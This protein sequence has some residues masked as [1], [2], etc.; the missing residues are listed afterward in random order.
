MKKVEPFFDPSCCSYRLSTKIR[1]HVERLIKCKDV[2]QETKSVLIELMDEDETNK[3][4]L[5][6]ESLTKLHKYIQRADPDYVGP[7]YIFSESCKCIRPK[8]RE[9]KQ[10]EARLKLLRL[11]SSQQMYNNMT[12]TVDRVVEKKIDEQ[13]DI[14]GSE[15][16][17]LK[18]LSG[19]MMAVINSFLV[20]ICTFIFC[21]KAVE[22]SLPQPNIIAQVSFGLLGS[23][24]VACAELYFLARVI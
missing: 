5:S 20:Y 12:A 24:V 21:F 11:R 4:T 14:N 13:I 22:Y 17:E 18:V 9:N 2:A 1:A 3:N 7:F 6:Y 10:L 16:K 8:P 15:T 23:T 19:S